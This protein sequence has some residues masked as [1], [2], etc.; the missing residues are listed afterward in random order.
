MT[1]VVTIT[2]SNPNHG[3]VGVQQTTIEGDSAGDTHVLNDGESVTLYVHDSAS[4]KVFEIPRAVQT[5]PLIPQDGST[6]QPGA[7][8]GP[9]PVEA[10]EPAPD[11]P[12]NSHPVE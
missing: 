12:P 2:S 1:T 6:P 7:P 11:L 4:L 10:P 3:K 5:P 9:T 8:E